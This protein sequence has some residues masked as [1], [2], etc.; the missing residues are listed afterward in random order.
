MY[1]LMIVAPLIFVCCT[2]LLGQ[3]DNVVFYCAYGEENKAPEI[4]TEM[5]GNNF[6]TSDAAEFAIDRL[7]K[8]LGLPRNFVIDPCPRIDNAAAIT[9]QGIRYIIYDKDFI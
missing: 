9:Y 6:K 4:C 1:R 3:G 7:L 2:R 5:R 8:A